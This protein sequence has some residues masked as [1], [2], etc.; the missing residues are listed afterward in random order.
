MLV[1]FILVLGFNVG[2]DMDYTYCWICGVNVLSTCS[3]GTLRLN[4]YIFIFN[5]KI[6]WG[7]RCY[8][9]SACW[10]MQPSQFFCLWYSL[11]LMYTRFIFQIFIYILS[12]H[13]I[14]CIF[15]AFS[16]GHISLKLLFLAL[17]TLQPK[18]VSVHASNI[19]SKQTAFTASS[20]LHNL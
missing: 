19:I 12:F 4:Y 11:N 1:A 13:I 7:I 14:Q 8:Q 5:F 18:E 10:T 9:H 20:R 6:S 16:N 17:P 3:W 2:W 15:T